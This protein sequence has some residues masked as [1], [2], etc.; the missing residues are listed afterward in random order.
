MKFGLITKLDNRKKS[1]KIWTVT[2]YWQVLKSFSFF[3]FM[4]NLEQSGSR[5][6]NAQ[7]VKLTFSL[8]VTFYFTK[9]E[10]ITKKSLIQLSD[11]CFK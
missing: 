3:K 9:N 6:P 7:S 4:A 8:T 5:I 10:I 2:S 1:K 11:Y